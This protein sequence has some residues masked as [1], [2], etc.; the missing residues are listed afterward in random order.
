MNFE[1]N[2]MQTKRKKI[3]PRILINLILLNN[4]N[5]FNLAYYCQISNYFNKKKMNE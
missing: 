4:N 5:S 2:G 1:D 3:F